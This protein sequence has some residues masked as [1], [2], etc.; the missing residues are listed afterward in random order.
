MA[1]FEE[2]MN[3]MLEEVIEEMASAMN[4]VRDQHTLGSI[5]SHV[6]PRDAAILYLNMTDYFHTGRLVSVEATEFHLSVALVCL[7]RL[8]RL[9]DDLKRRIEWLEGAVVPRDDI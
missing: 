5:V 9:V 2:R 3:N 7:G 1:S 6:P 8:V 4:A